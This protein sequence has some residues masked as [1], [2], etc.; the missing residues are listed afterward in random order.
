MIPY[1]VF[2]QIRGV[3]TY[4]AS[5]GSLGSGPLEIGFI[6]DAHSLKP[7]DVI[8]VEGS[9]ILVQEIDPAITFSDPPRVTYTY[10][11]KWEDHDFQFSD[12]PW[13]LYMI[14]RLCREAELC[15]EMSR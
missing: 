1:R 4:E 5:S 15:E 7:G 8:Q 12:G 6:T 13:S 10:L 9:F 11:P 2:K 3:L 14:A